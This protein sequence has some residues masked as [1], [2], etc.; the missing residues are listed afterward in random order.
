[1]KHS[2]FK[3]KR[4]PGKLGDKAPHKPILL[5]SI[6]ELFDEGVLWDN[7]IE[8]LPQLVATFKNIWSKLV[9]NANW[10]PKIFLPFFH[11]SGDGFWHLKTIP[12]ANIILTN[13]YSPKSL[14]SLRDSI[15][16][17]YFDDHIYREI[18]DPGKRAILRQQ[19]LDFYFNSGQYEQAD[20]QR[21]ARSYLQKVENDFLVGQVSEN[22]FIEKEARSVIFKSEVSRIY[23]YQCAVTGLKISTVT[24]IQ[25]VDACHIKPWSDSKDDSIT[26]GISLSPT[27]HRAFDRFLLSV[28]ENY[29]VILSSSFHEEGN[30]PYGLTKLAGKSIKLPEK[31]EWF[32]SQEALQWHRANLI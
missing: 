7:R 16:Y 10:Q 2:F 23:G 5:L 17:G 24:N 26:N 20:V 15:Y 9:N 21:G 3:L 6:L 22:S 12:G 25:M 19:L 29:R 27:I 18:I 31:A 1:M 32:P 13:S 28:D 30:N 11:L 4:A 8:I 14:A